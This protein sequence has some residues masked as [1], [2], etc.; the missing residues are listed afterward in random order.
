[1][2]RCAAEA[3]G[4]ENVVEPEPSMGAEDMAFYLERCKGCFFFLGVGRKRV[5][6][7]TIRNS[8]SMKT[9]C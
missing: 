6:P 1:V 5:I 9:F 4:A 2:G 3:V 7:F 8:I